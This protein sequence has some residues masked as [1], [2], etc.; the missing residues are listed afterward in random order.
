MFGTRLGCGDRTYRR[1][2]TA[3]RRLMLRHRNGVKVDKYLTVLQ[4]QTDIAGIAGR[5]Q[6]GPMSVKA[7]K[8]GEVNLNYDGWFIYGEVNADVVSW[9]YVRDSS[10]PNGLR[11]VNYRVDSKR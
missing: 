5:Y 10:G 2:T 1:G 9:Y 3:G 11:L 8:N 4:P 7:L 6:C